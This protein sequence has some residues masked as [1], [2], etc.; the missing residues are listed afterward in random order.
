MSS[1][2][3]YELNLITERQK[4]KRKSHLSERMRSIAPEDKSALVDIMLSGFLDPQFHDRNNRIAAARDIEAY[5]TGKKHSPLLNCSCGY[6]E[7][8]ILI[9]VCLIS[10]WKERDCPLID[11]IVV[12]NNYK[13]RHISSIVFQ[14]SLDRLILAGYTKVRAVISEENILPKNL[15]RR[16]G[17]TKLG[18]L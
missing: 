1:I 7:E 9:G 4:Y 17:F 11:C 18:K 5:F 14:A 13:G 6:W 10:Y 12:H 3:E 8:R 15:A 16:L 2:Y